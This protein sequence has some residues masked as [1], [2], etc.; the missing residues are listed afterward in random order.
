[1]LE[2]VLAVS[3]WLAWCRIWNLEDQVNKLKRK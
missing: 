1:M 3:L 2:L